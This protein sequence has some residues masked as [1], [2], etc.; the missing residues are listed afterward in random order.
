[1]TSVTPSAFSANYV[2]I[3]IGPAPTTSAVEPGS[4]PDTLTACHA[5]LVYF[6][7]SATRMLVEKSGAST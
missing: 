5:L 7:I 6:I 4:M 3:P 2:P 1:M